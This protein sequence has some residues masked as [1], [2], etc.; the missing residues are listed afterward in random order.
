[1]CHTIFVASALLYAYN[2]ELYKAYPDINPIGLCCY[3][4]PSFSPDGEYLLFAFQDQ[5]GGASSTTQIYYVLYSN[6]GTGASFDPL[7][8]PDI[9]FVCCC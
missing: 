5:L 1:M 9:L 2:T 6:I 7:P 4:D 3:R 8:L